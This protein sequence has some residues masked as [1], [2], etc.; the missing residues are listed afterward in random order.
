MEAGLDSLGV[1]ELRTAAELAFGI[2]LPA[3][4]AFD[5]PTLGAMA[6]FIANRLP[7]DQANQV[8]SLKAHAFI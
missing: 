5:Y 2:N 3:T 8:D 7:E 4:L 6:Q 1:V